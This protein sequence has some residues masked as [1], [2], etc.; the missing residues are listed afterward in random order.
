MV[1]VFVFALVAHFKRDGGR[2]VPV[3]L[4]VG[5][6]LGGGGSESGP[7]IAV[8]GAVLVVG[9]RLRLGFSGACRGE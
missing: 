9:I 4:G 7:R 2:R 3:V 5:V 1:V 8:P 6:V